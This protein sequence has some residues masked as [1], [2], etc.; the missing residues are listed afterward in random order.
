MLLLT[1]FDD[2]QSKHFNQGSGFALAYDFLEDTMIIKRY[3]SESIAGRFPLHEPW[4]KLIIKEN[5]DG[6]QTIGSPAQNAQHIVDN[7]LP[8]L[9]PDRGFAIVV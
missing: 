6:I 1:I 8:N 4:Y 9:D 2:L 3:Q 7:V 5:D